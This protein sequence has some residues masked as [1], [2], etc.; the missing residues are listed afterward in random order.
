MEYFVLIK[1]NRTLICGFNWSILLG[2]TNTIVNQGTCGK[3]EMLQ[4][5]FMLFKFLF[6]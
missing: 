1:D 2:I 5:G 6:P 3:V 4:L